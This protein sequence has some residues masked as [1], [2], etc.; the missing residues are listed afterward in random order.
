MNLQPERKLVEKRAEMH[1]EE[2][3]EA[4]K[5]VTRAKG[6]TCGTCIYYRET[7]CAGQ[8]ALNGDALVILTPQAVA[9]SSHEPPPAKPARPR[10]AAR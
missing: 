1:G 9:C 4:E 5:I 10:R 2:G 7:F 3:A 8:T 6:R